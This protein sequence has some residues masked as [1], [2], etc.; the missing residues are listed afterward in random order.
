[1]ECRPAPRGA[2][3][4]CRRA[5]RR[6]E[7]SGTGVAHRGV[8]VPTGPVGSSQRERRGARWPRRLGTTTYYWQVR[9]E[10]TIGMIEADSGAWWTFA[11]FTEGGGAPPAAFGKTGPPNG[12]TGRATSLSLT[13]QASSE[14]TS[15][16]YCYDTVNCN[17]F[18]GGLRWNARQVQLL[19]RAAVG[20]E[21]TQALYGS[22]HSYYRR[23][24][25]GAW[26]GRAW[27]V[28]VLAGVLGC[29]WALPRG[30]ATATYVAIVVSVAAL[31]YA[32]TR[33]TRINS[34]WDGYFNGYEDGKK[35]GV[36]DAIGLNEDEKE[37][38]ERAREMELF[39]HQF[40]EC[41]GPWARIEKPCG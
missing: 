2:P 29:F 22:Y 33:L 18:S 8:V 36:L 38:A 3:P 37:L 14:A 27:L 25:A 40:P 16:E 4:A 11:T 7:A 34:H 35:A 41:A 10:N 26:N 12:A 28:L 30:L 15:Y 19:Q 39:E 21:Q 23:R 13:W 31:A 6:W 17:I 9:A 1:M 32:A 24:I 5:G 20:N